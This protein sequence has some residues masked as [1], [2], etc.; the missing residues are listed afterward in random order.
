MLVSD[1]YRIIRLN[2]TFH[3]INTSDLLNKAKDILTDP[4]YLSI[5]SL[6]FFTIIFKLAKRKQKTEEPKIVILKE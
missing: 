3:G 1:N 6:T 2:N 5:I 4:I